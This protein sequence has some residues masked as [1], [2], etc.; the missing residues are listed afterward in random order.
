MALFDK[1]PGDSNKTANS[2]KVTMPSRNYA[3]IYQ[4]TA[5]DPGHTKGSAL[6]TNGNETADAAPQAKPKSGH[7]PLHSGEEGAGTKHRVATGFD[8]GSLSGGL[9]V[10]YRVEIDQHD[11]DGKTDGYGFSSKFT[12][13]P[14]YN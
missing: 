6:T 14:M 8:S 4:T 10:T 5:A 1:D 7:Q 12:P 11:R 9:D 3:I 13:H 2:N